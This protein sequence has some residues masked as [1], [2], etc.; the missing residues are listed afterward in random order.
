VSDSPA[1]GSLAQPLGLDF[2][3][4]ATAP[5][6]RVH[7]QVSATISSST[8]PADSARGRPSPS[9]DGCRDPRI[10]SG[11][12]YCVVAHCSSLTKPSII[13]IGVERERTSERKEAVA[14]GL[15]PYCRSVRKLG[16]GSIVAI[17]G[18]RT[19]WHLARRDPGCR[20]I[21]RRRHARWKNR[22]S[23][24]AEIPTTPLP[25][26]NTPLGSP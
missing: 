13:T 16:L 19:W 15:C 10:A 7:A 1:T 4:V 12:L 18:T 5:G 2:R 6:L 26:R 8:H 25:V 17:S 21:A 14:M 20:R 11:Y 24:W 22:A 3:F 9:R 23:P